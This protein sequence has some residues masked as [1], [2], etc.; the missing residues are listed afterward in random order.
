MDLWILAGQSNM[1]G[2]GDLVDLEAPSSSVRMFAHGD[3]WKT[4]EDPLHWLLEAN[5]VVHHPDLT[6]SDLERERANHRANR[7]K[8]AGCGLTFAKRIAE[9]TGRT[10]GLIPC[11]HGGTSME[12]WSPGK[13]DEGGAS[14]YGAMLRRVQL[15]IETSGG[16]L[17]GILW[18]Q[19]ESDAWGEASL[20]YR[21][22]MHEL[23]AACRSDFNDPELA[24]YL[25]QLGVFAN[26]G[27]ATQDDIRAWCRV[28]ET[29]R[30]LPSEISHTATVPAID[31]D[32]D[33]GIH[34]GSVGQKRLGR[35][36][37][38]VALEQ[39]YRQPAPAGIGLES[40]KRHGDQI[41]VVFSGVHG[42]LRAPDPS[43]RVPGFALEQNGIVESKHIYRTTVES[44]TSVRIRLGSVP[45]DGAQLWYGWGYDPFC[46]LTDSADMAV[47]AFGPIP[48]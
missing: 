1:E 20:L 29:Q 18:Y 11:A 46:Q 4:A 30:L 23:I 5:D 40:V 48:V 3:F 44:E 14:F 39:T 36:L 2:C 38:N 37:A 8:G 6:G 42:E 16:H 41:K 17:R 32:L 22:R 12:Q 43:G 26:T 10:V 21:K 28:R 33:D 25:V 24:F 9:S 27:P 15:A 19:G 34:I 13:K 47:P 7:T 35:R 31:L 45:Q